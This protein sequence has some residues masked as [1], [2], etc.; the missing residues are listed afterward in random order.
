MIRFR[1]KTLF[2]VTLIVAVFAIVFLFMRGAVWV[3][4]GM[5]IIADPDVAAGIDGVVLI[6][7]LWAVGVLVS[8]FI[9]ALVG[10]FLLGRNYGGRTGSAK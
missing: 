5:L 3:E 1:L 2:A 6:G 7:R 10:G 9:A 4:D 8:I